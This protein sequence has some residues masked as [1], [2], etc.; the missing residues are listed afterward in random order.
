M[1]D[2]VRVALIGAG[3]A[4]LVHGRNFSAGVP[5]ARLVAIADPVAETRQ[6]VAAELGCRRTLADPVDAATDDGCAD[7]SCNGAEPDVRANA[8]DD[9]AAE[10]ASGGACGGIAGLTCAADEW[11]DYDACGAGAASDPNTRCDCAA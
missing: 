1:T 8:P 4:G 7:E 11:C 3:R 6:R 2:L 5:G 9:G 10:A